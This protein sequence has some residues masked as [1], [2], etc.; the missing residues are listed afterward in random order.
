MPYQFSY[1]FNIIIFHFNVITQNTT[2]TATYAQSNA[3]T[4]AFITIISCVAGLQK[5][6]DCANGRRGK[7]VRAD[8]QVN[9][10]GK[11]ANV[12]GR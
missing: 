11:N 4:D 3:Q 8:E 1:N 5:H 10:C 6:F 2:T 9:K 12:N 7:N